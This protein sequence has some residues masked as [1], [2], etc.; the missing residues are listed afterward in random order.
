MK[1]Q[2]RKLLAGASVFALTASLLPTG[3][4]VTAA[5]S[6]AGTPYT[7]EG[8][9]DVTV[10]HVIVNQVYGGSDDG[11]ASHSFIELYNQTAEDVDLTGWRLAYRSSEDGDDS[12]QWSYL[13]LTGVIRAKGYYLVRCGATSGTDYDG[14][15]GRSGVGYPASQ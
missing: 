8:T 15:G 7:A 9:Y 13:E 14:T 1:R 10:P 5:G 6:E 4:T 3:L 11:A 12:G 2:W